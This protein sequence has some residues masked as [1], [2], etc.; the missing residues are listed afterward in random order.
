MVRNS[1]SFWRAKS[2]N[3][4]CLP[5][6]RSSICTLCPFSKNFPICDTFVSRSCCAAPKVMRTILRSPVSSD[7]RCF[8]SCFSFSYRY[9][10]KLIIFATGG[11][12]RGAISTR[13][14]S[15]SRAARNASSRVRIPRF[16]PLSVMTRR[17]FAV[18][19][20][21]TLS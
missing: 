21:F 4:I 5:R 17:E 14:I 15:L 8:L 19:A 12:A 10:S 7:A 13:S 2:L 20:S 1:W 6:R 16:S 9:L 3:R 11:F 18:I